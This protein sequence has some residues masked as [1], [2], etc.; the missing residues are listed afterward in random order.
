MGK[1]SLST[2]AALSE[3]VIESSKADLAI[4]NHQ[5]GTVYEIKTDLDNL[6]RLKYQLENYYNVFSEVYVVT[7]E[8]NYYPVYRYIKEFK[9]SVGIIVLT[10]S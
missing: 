4:I 9:S 8:K 10:K 6:D 3:I 5:K 2:T 1:Y 7:S